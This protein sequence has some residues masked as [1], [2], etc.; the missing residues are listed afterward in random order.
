MQIIV[1][2]STGR[3]VVAKRFDFLR[4]LVSSPRGV[5][6]VEK[7]YIV[8]VDFTRRYADNWT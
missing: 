3:M 7:V 1:H 5:N 8:D 6:V 4:I 2:S